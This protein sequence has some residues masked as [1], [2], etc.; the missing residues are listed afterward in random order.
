MHTFGS[1]LNSLFIQG[2]D[3][4]SANILFLGDSNTYDLP[5]NWTGYLRSN[6]KMRNAKI[7][8][9]N[10]ATTEWMKSALSEDLAKGNR[11]DYIFI[12]G[13][14]NDIYSTGT[15]QGKVRAIQNINDMVNMLRRAKNTEGKFPKIVV[16]NMACDKLRDESLRYSINEQFGNEFYRELL[17]TPNVQLIPTREVLKMGKVP[18]QSLSQKDLLSLRKTLCR[19]NLCH[20]NTSANKVLADY[21][22][23]NVFKL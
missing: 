12:W 17:M 15:K 5:N 8:Q 10:G 23:K 4:S 7:I 20:L 14:V 21:I 18:C 13:G 3:P 16:I 11:Y 1:I 6:L 9:K 19:D 22:Q 2:K